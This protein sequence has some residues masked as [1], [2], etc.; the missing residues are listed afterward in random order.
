MSHWKAE[1]AVWKVS[2]LGGEGLRVVWAEGRRRGLQCG[3]DTGLWPQSEKQT[4]PLESWATVSERKPRTQKHT[5]PVHMDSEAVTCPVET[6]T[7][8]TAE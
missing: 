1:M 2:L 3:R 6:L 5:L 8:F 7:T 4:Q